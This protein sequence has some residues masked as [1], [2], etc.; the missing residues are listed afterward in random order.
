MKENAEMIQQ[1]EKKLKS[2]RAEFEQKVIRAKQQLQ[3]VSDYCERTGTKRL[4]GLQDTSCAT[5]LYIV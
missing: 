5:F 1:R 2:E 3:K 4:P